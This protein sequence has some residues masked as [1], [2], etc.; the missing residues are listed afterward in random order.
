M[1]NPYRQQINTGNRSMRV[2]SIKEQ[3]FQQTDGGRVVFSTNV[4]NVTAGNISIRVIFTT[5]KLIRVFFTINQS[6]AVTFTVNQLVGIALTTNQSTW[7][8]PTMIILIIYCQQIYFGNLYHHSINI[9]TFMA[10]L[11]VIY[12]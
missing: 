2:I 11:Q 1:G 12:Q 7:V 4:D 3:P 9:G 10:N 6:I 5:D 8:M